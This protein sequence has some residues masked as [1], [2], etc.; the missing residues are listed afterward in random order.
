MYLRFN[1][2]ESQGEMINGNDEP[3][4]AALTTGMMDC[5]NIGMM[6]WRPSGK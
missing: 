1:G 6:G 5:W 2:K 3:R 4:I